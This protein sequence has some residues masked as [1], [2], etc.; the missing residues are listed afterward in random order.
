MVLLHL[1]I[2]VLI[3]IWFIELL[4]PYHG[5]IR[6]NRSLIILHSLLFFSTALTVLLG[7][8]YAEYYDYGEEIDSH[9]FWGYVFAGCVAFTYTLHLLRRISERLVPLTVYYLSLIACTASMTIT[10][11]IGGE[12]IHGKGFLTKP[13]EQESSPTIAESPVPE[14]LPSMAT[15]APQAAPTKTVVPPRST[16]VPKPVIAETT[17]PEPEPEPSMDMAMDPMMGDEMAAMDNMDMMMAPTME[18]APQPAATA[19]ADPRLASFESAHKAFKT[20]C[21]NCHGPTKQKGKYRMDSA[22]AI[23]TPGKSKLAPIVAGKPEESELV[24]RIRLPR[25]DD[26]V[27]PPE[28]K[29]ALPAESIEAIVAWVTAGAYWP[30]KGERSKYTEVYVEMNDADTDKLIEQI[31]VTGAKAE[32]NAWND[33]RVRI[34]LGVV[35]P[36][37]LETALKELPKFGDKLIWLDAS[38][39]E[40]PQSFFQQLPKFQNL[41]RLHLDGSNVSDANL[42]S[43][44]QLPKLNSLNLYN[45]A[46]SDT[47]SKHLIHSANLSRIYLTNTKVTKAGIQTLQDSQAKLEIIYR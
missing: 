36:G 40:L 7:L 19:A 16:E 38:N 14:Q 25:H 5:D 9:E 33:L 12:M 31:S 11:H 39:L 24:H 34:D 46:I 41:E 32:Y 6:R 42:E 13:F 21:F 30:K 4:P 23:M 15:D 45:T 3:A 28:E 43:I 10:G 44:A 8:A 18:P 35:E 27:M 1:P 26:D 47:G 2:G 17:Q 29:A 22:V 20:H 37:Q